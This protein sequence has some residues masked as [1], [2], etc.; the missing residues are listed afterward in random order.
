[1]YTWC[2]VSRGGGGGISHKIIKFLF[3]YVVKNGHI[4]QKISKVIPYSETYLP[5]TDSLLSSN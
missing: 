2:L 5:D 1:M 4:D 3:D